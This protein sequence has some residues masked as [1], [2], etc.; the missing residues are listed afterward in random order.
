[1]WTK[2]FICVLFVY[3]VTADTST[4]D[5]K[6]EKLGRSMEDFI[7]ELQEQLT[8]NLKSS[9]ARIEKL[10]VLQNKTSSAMKRHLIYGGRRLA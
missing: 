10:G 7:R 8:M 9:D 3:L 2:L 5:P 4:M 6:N 1:M